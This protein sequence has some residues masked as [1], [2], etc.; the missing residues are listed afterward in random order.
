VVECVGEGG[1]RGWGG[2]GWV[3]GGGWGVVGGVGGGGALIY[4]CC[5]SVN[6]TECEITCSISWLESPPEDIHHHQCRLSA[7]GFHTNTLN[8]KV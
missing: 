7:L 8:C 2:G 4:N 3:G 1:V 5:E 6:K